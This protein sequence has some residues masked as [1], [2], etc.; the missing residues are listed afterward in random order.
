VTV[1]FPDGAE[2]AAD[3]K[4]EH[5]SGELLSIVVTYAPGNYDRTLSPDGAAVQRAI[6]SGWNV[7]KCGAHLMEDAIDWDAVDVIRVL[8]KAGVDVNRRNSQGRSFLY[9]ADDRDFENAIKALFDNGAKPVAIVDGQPQPP[10]WI[11]MGSP[12]TLN[13]FLDHGLDPNA[14]DDE[15]LMAYKDI[16]EAMAAQ[17]DL[18]E[19]LARFEPRLVKMAPER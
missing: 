7:P 6:K 17:S 12:A 18:V 3:V 19:P 2:F 10:V 15:V 1:S 8:A 4:S 9:Q 16:D 13:L 5:D 11:A 14:T